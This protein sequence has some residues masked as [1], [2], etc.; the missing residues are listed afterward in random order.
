MAKPSWLSVKPASGSGSRSVTVST[1][2]EHT[3]RL[4]RQGVLTFK[5]AN[6][7]NV[8]RNV[9]QAGKPEFADIAESAS[10]PKE[11]KTVTIAGVSNSKILTFSLGTG[12]LQV[13]LPKQYKANSVNTDNG[14]EITGDPGATA[15]YNFSI[16]I[17]VPANGE[18]TEQTRQ[19]I[20]T[21]EGGHQDVCLLTLA[22]GD[23]YLTVTEG[24]INLTYQGTGV[25]VAISSNTSWTVE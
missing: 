15:T 8:T 18:I 19:I 4:Q 16:A 7:P 14:A 23:A 10:S 1:S 20:V 6:C 24:D 22:A 11:G 21:D 2:T 3:G 12:E 25:E 5:A 17:T 13:E 9:I